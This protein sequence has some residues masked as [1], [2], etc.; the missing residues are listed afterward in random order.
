MALR[1]PLVIVAGL[2]EQ[3]QA[4]DTLD[5]TV[6]EIE[7][8][9]QT[10]GEAGGIVIGSPVY[11]SAADTV[12]KAEANAS[13]TI[14][15]I[16]IAKSTFVTTGTGTVQ[17]SGVLTLTTAQW[18]AVATGDSQSGGLT[19][20]AVYYLDDAV[21]GEITVTAPTDAG[22]YVLRLGKGISTTELLIDIGEPIL[23]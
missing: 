19:A 10:S 18:D 12:K 17:T 7:T 14:E 22:K 3:I 1:K 8:I 16:G 9:T 4:G 6:A 23:L 20:G 13:G 15:A 11:S 2:V 5:A 21:V